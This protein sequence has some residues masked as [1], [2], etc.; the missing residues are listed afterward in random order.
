MKTHH[1]PA[2]ARVLGIALM[3]MTVAC[4][5]IVDAVVKRMSGAID[6]L[7][8]IALRYVFGFLITTA[9][10]NPWTRPGIMHSRARGLQAGRAL[11]AITATTCS[12]FALPHLPLTQ[13]TAI[14]FA[15]PLIV[16][17]LAGPLI[18]EWVGR[19]RLAAIL[20]G[21]AGVLMVT[22]PGLSMHPAVVLPVGTACFNALFVVATR[23]IAAHDRAETTMIYSGLVGA[24]LFLPVLPFVWKAPSDP[25][26]WFGLAVVCILAPLGQWLLILA[27]RGAPAPVLAPFSYVQLIFAALLGYLVFGQAPDGWTLF[28]GAMIMAS[29]LYLLHRERRRNVPPAPVAP[30]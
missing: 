1:R 10:V 8:I 14:S 13:F 27:Y 7:Q 4:F 25:L 19:R 6:P 18:G 16:A 23:F 12:F 26:V 11:C 2:A 5:A 3:L 22:R 28:G 9:F 15:A 24:V 21:F 29:G 17:L 30:V 20:F